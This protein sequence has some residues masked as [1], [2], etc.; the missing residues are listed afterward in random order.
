M[1]LGCF[2]VGNN[3]VPRELVARKG[4][5]SIEDL[6]GKTFGVQSIGGGFWL[7]TMVVLDALAIDPDK[8]KLN[9][10]ID[11]DTAYAAA[12]SD[13]GGTCSRRVTA[14]AASRRS[15]V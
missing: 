15:A 2:A 12:S 7:S 1:K 3:K 6:R 8:Y 11:A 5:E 14:S 9:M 4:I 13:E 10:H